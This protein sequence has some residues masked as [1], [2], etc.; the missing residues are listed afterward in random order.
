MS[1]TLGGQ[2]QGTNQSNTT[3]T[4]NPNHKSAN[5]AHGYCRFALRA[6]TGA[7]WGELVYASL[8]C[9]EPLK[10]LGILTMIEQQ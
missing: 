9:L 7:N 4:T 6:V 10:C 1:I 5:K 3:G 8:L 2:A